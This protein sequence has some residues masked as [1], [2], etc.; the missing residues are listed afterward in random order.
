MYGDFLLLTHRDELMTEE[1]Y[2][3][4]GERFYGGVSYQEYLKNRI[5]SEIRLYNRKT[6]ETKT[7]AS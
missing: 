3:D 7:I 6:G 5:P 1:E 2:L 4:W